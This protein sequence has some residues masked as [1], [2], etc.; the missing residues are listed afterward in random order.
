MDLFKEYCLIGG[1]PEVVE[2]YLQRR[3]LVEIG[4][5]YESLVIT[6]LE[7]V[8]KYAQAETQRR[9]IRHLINNVFR[10]A[11]ERIKFEGFA[12]TNYK[13]KD[14]SE[15]FRILEKTFLLSLVYPT[16]TSKPPLAEN[17]RKSPKLQVLDT[18][19]VNYY[20]GARMSILSGDRLESIYDGK[21]AE[22]IVGQE[23]LAVESKPWSKNTFWVKEKKQSSAEIDYIIQA[24]DMLFPVEVKLGKAGRLRSL[25]EY[26]DLCPHNIAVRIYSGELKIETLKTLRGKEFVLLNLPFYLTTKVKDYLKKLSTSES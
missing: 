19:L 7:D 23:L 10:K 22:H 24:D 2:N 11:G 4:K 21:I 18:G 26:I 6:Y 12:E 8:E 14:V 13:S 5:I 17:L 20:S 3:D 9:I 1:M 16:T 15:C 25:M